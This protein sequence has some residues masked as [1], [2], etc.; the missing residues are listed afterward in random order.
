MNRFERKLIRRSCVARQRDV[1][2]ERGSRIGKNALVCK[3]A[4]QMPLQREQ[5]L[6]RGMHADP[7]DAALREIAD[8]VHCQRHVRYRKSGQDFL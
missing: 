5:S 8:P 3:R 6:R 1:R 7:C 2:F 4:H